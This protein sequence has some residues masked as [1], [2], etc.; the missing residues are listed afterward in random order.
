MT[1]LL[2]TP[3]DISKVPFSKYGSYLAVCFDPGM[4][5]FTIH[6]ARRMFGTDMIFHLTF[7]HDDNTVEYEVTATPWL[8]H[9]TAAQGTAWIYMRGDD[10]VVI[11]GKGL[12]IKL[13]MVSGKVS[14]GYEQES[15]PTRYGIQIADR[16]YKLIRV[17]ARLYATIDVLK[18]LAE[19]VGAYDK[20]PGGQQRNC[21]T[22]L[23]VKP[24]DDGILVNLEIAQIETRK[25]PGSINTDKEIKLV[26]KEW[27][28]FR[29]MM[30]AVPVDR[31]AIAEMTW[32]NIWSS[33]VRAEDCYRYDAMLMS[34]KFMCSVWTW[35]H[36]F[37]AL[38]IA[39]ADVRKGVEQFLLPFELQAES[40]ALPDFFSPHNEKVWGVTKP[41][42]HG[43]CFHRLMSRYKIDKKTVR[44][45]YGKLQRWTDWWMICRDSDQDGIPDY[46]QG[47][48]SGWD[49]STVFDTGYFI[50]SPD[51]ASYLV[52][53]MKALAEM[54]G[55]LGDPKS[56]KYWQKRGDLLLQKFYEHN[57][58]GTHFVA[59]VSRT[60]EH[61]ENPTSLQTVMPLVLG[62]HLDQDKFNRLVTILEQEF[63]TANG[64]ATE[65]LKSPLYE[66]DSY[67]RGPI[68]A[69]T[70]YLLVDGLRRGGREDLASKIARGFCDMIKEKAGGNYENF[71][72]STGRGLRAPGYTWTASV[73]MLLLSEFLSKN[74]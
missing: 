31:L 46:P 24:E 47:C 67:W 50:E 69:P 28:K 60:H 39:M 18:G 12:G 65:A 17:D 29:S 38:A 41:P 23:I 33:F 27:E 66:D 44:K 73:H 34:K 9:I 19:T 54:A 4:K 61:N 51:L 52:L 30:P 10:A 26:K 5:I 11:E 35:D 72:A 7:E 21:N 43:W 68:W 58:K 16:T 37:N 64:P 63:L 74:V 55:T 62:E 15:Y 56:K 49:N 2:N 20:S 45:V 57:W 36:C 70:T 53:Q 14:W 48:D 59:P 6:N 71:D 8:V 22:I 3:I 40:G 13:E 25:R 42:I 1:D 32:Y